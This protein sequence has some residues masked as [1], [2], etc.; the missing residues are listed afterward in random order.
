MPFHSIAYV[1]YALWKV[2]AYGRASNMM[3]KSKYKGLVSGTDPSKKGICPDIQERSVAVP[4]R[5][6]LFASVTTCS[7]DITSIW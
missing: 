1:H 3:Y 4:L 7:A 2:L 6:L 5:A